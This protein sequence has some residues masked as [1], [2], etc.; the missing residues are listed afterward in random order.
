MTFF[1]YILIFLHSQFEYWLTILP[2]LRLLHF[3]YLLNRCW[4][5]LVIIRRWWSVRKFLNG[6]AHPHNSFTFFNRL[7]FRLFGQMILMLRA[8]HLIH[9]KLTFTGQPLTIFSLALCRFPLENLPRWY[10]VQLSKDYII[11]I[12]LDLLLTIEHLPI[13]HL[14]RSNTK[15]TPDLIGMIAEFGKLIW[16]EM[17]TLLLLLIIFICNLLLWFLISLCLLGDVYI[18]HWWFLNV[19]ILLL[20][21]WQ[22]EMFWRLRCCCI[23]S[24]CHVVYLGDK[25]GTLLF[26]V[27][28]FIGSCRQTN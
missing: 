18:T 7:C 25:I 22:A 16:S 15:A 26:H 1:K 10:R 8:T 9:L 23:F 21:G 2:C 17:L 24:T 13:M 27:E 5:S 20:F 3:L 12:T 6:S 14:L 4:R 19:K 11:L 28:I